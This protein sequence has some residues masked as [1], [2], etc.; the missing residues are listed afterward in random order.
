MEFAKNPVLESYWHWGGMSVAVTAAEMF[1]HLA[2]VEESHP[3]I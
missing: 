3:S 1:A 2:L